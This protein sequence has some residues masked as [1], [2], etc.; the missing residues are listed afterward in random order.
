MTR[1]IKLTNSLINISYITKVVSYE[2][3]HLLYL[4]NIDIRGFFCITIG[5][6]NSNTEYI[7]VNKDTEPK[8]YQ[9]VSE[10]IAK[11]NNDI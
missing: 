2:K 9:I 10:W 5:S 1:F 6:L 8:D 4:N 11:I 7:A 3:T